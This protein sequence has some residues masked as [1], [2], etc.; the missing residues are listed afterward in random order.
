MLTRSIILVLVA[1]L[2]GLMSLLAPAAAAELKYSVAEVRGGSV[3]YV[4]GSG[5]GRKEEIF[6]DCGDG[7]NPASVTTANGKGNFS[8]EGDLPAGCPP[9]NCAGWLTAGNQSIP[10]DITYSP[11]DLPSDP[12]E[13]L[14]LINARPVSHGGDAVRAVGFVEYETET[15]DGTEVWVVSG[16]ADTFL[17][18]W[19]LTLDLK[20]T[21]RTG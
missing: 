13:G 2:C 8:F 17:R 10:V 16:G 18:Y 20:R 5:A 7:C 14:C 12:P 6:W 1:G 19:T 21:E 15:A 4:K 9:D 11:S 3:V